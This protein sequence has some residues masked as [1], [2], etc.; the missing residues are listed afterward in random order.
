MS[1]TR[2]L[3]V[4]VLASV[5]AAVAVISAVAVVMVATMTPTTVMEPTVDDTAPDTS[6]PSPPATPIDDNN[7]NTGDDVNDGLLELPVI[8]AMQLNASRIP[9]EFAKTNNAFAVDLYKHGALSGDASANVFFSPAS[10]HM[11]F[12]MLYEAAGGTAA[13]ELEDAFGYNPDVEARHNTTAHTMSALNRDDGHSELAMANAIWT[14]D[15]LHPLYADILHNTYLA[16]IESVVFPKPAADMINAW[17]S[18]KTRGKI[19]VVV[20][21]DMLSVQTVSVLTNAI[22]FKGTW[23]TQFP[24]GATAESDFWPGDGTGETSTSA[25]F[26]KVTGSFDY[27]KSD[28]AQVLRMPYKGDKLS[29]LVILPT[30]RDG[31]TALEESI[32]AEKID[33]WREDLRPSTVVVEMPKFTMKVKY[34]LNEP[35]MD[36]GVKKIFGGGN[37][38]DGDDTNLSGMH[39]SPFRAP[40][41]SAVLHDAFVDVNEEGTEAAAVTTIATMTEE[42]P[43]PPPRFIADHSFIF[44]IQDDESGAILFMGK[45]ADTTA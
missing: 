34:V 20:T 21:A 29:M 3:P 4:I 6:S 35:L 16:D 30:A 11:A 24:E 45:L 37:N 41:V 5:I 14:A 28:G 25:D 17:A 12:S 42:E 19:P 44:L 10:L 8:D 9:A 33:Q 13:T 31:I 22:Y 15:R 26:M 40:F 36:L 32:T 18:E 39:L 27:T 1:G 7:A 38:N 2:K 23:V 43:P